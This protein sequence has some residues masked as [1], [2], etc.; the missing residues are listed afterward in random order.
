LITLETIF[1]ISYFRGMNET[2]S[3]MKQPNNAIDSK[4]IIGIL[5]YIWISKR[6]NEKK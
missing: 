5:L 4:T 2:S 6:I 1:I 3:K